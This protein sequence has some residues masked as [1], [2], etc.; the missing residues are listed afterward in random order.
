MTTEKN[1][2][3]FNLHNVIS[4]N[5]PILD[6]EITNADIY[7]EIAGLRSNK[8]CGPDGIPNEVLKTLPDS[9]ILLLKQL[10]NSVMTTGKYPAIWTNS[11]IHPIFKNGYKN[12]PSNYREFGDIHLLLY[13]DDIAIIGESRMNLQKMIKILKEYLDENLMTLNESKSKI[14]VFRNGGRLC[15]FLPASGGG[16]R[17]ELASREEPGESR[18]AA[19]DGY[20]V[21]AH[22]HTHCA[23][24][25][26]VPSNSLAF[27]SLRRCSFG[28]HVADIT[29]R[30]ALHALP[31]PGHPASSQPICIACGSSDLSLAHRYWSCSAV[32]PLIRE[33]FSI[34][35]RPPELQSWIFAKSL[36]YKELETYRKVRTTG[37]KV[38]EAYKIVCTT[39]NKVLRAYRKVRTKEN[40]VLEAYR[41]VRT[42]ENKV[43]E[44]YRRVRTKSNKV[45][46]AYKRVRT[47]G[48]KVLETYRRSCTTRRV[49]TKENK[50]LETYRRAY[51]TRYWKLTYR[52]VRTTGNKVL[53]TYRKV[54]T[55]GNKV[56][57]AYRRVCTKG[58]KVLEAYKRVRTKSNKVLEAY[59]RVRTKSNKVLETYR[60]VRTKGNKVL[61]AYRRV[62]TKI[63]MVL[64]SY[65]RVRTKSNKVL[66]AYKRVRTKG[67]KVLEAYRRV[68]TKRNMV[69]DSYRRVRTKSNNVL[70]AYK[71]V[72]TKGNKVLETYRRPCTTRYW[73]LIEELILQGTGNL[74]IEEFVLRATRR[75]R[76]KGNKVPE[77][78]RRAYTT[79]YWKFTYRRVSTTR[80]WKLTY[81]RVRTTG[82]KGAKESLKKYRKTNRLED[83]ECYAS[84]R[85]K[86]LALLDLKRKGFDNEKQEILRNA[87]DSKTFWKTIALYKSTSII[88]GE[89]SIQDWLNFYRELMTTEKNLRICNLHNVISQNDPIL[90]SEITNADIYKEIAGLRSNKACG[91]DGIPNEV[92][93]TLPDSYILLLKQLYNSVMTTGKYPAIWT[94]ST[95]HPIFKNGYKN[96]PSNYREFGDIHLLLYADDIA[97]IGES[98]I[99]LQKK[100]KILK[101]YLDENLM[102]LNESKSKIMVFRNGEDDIVL[103]ED[104]SLFGKYVSVASNF[105]VAAISPMKDLIAKEIIFDDII[106]KKHIASKFIGY[107]FVTNFIDR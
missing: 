43:L 78:Y 98:R 41:R 12:S 19:R 61:E 5:D 22:Q 34:I 6:S 50:D 29:L 84:S 72:R 32:R 62:R 49:R 23:P 99:N 2:R 71:R 67:N 51:T 101:E 28:G 46:G 36:Y 92:L 39:G 70:E 7:K 56:Q 13:A 82:N 11:T 66:E 14:M 76:T 75:V 64:D 107:I 8:A 69:L 10:Y 25:V 21:L 3:I 106:E 87:K 94:N 60:K 86:Y 96:S 38:L 103:G 100:I 97:I 59:R 40:K 73:K 55:T 37:N 31:H 33:A 9:Y 42:K 44:A 1:L 4:Q 102:T 68:R 24:V 35:G 89:I 63:N 57:E 17:G 30:L 65:R 104:S 53:E 54:R 95:I 48:N 20:A 80:Y 15:S 74:L 26:D 81:K 105:M 52:R 47:K 90:D 79:R 91:P 93:K 18:G 83:R 85:K 77:T 45:L 88:Q 58:N 27:S 16:K